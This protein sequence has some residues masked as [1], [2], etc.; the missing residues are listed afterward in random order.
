MSSH[1]WFSPCLLPWYR[2]F[3]RPLP[4]RATRDPYLIWLSET[5]L[6]QTRVDQGLP[7][8]IRFKER[9]PT[10]QALAEANEQEV[11]KAWQ[12]LGYYSRARNL[13]AA[14][15]HVVKEHKGHFPRTVEGLLGLQGVGDYTASAIASICFNRPEAVVDGNVYRV[16]ARVFG[17]GTAID[18]S[19][20][21]KQ[22]KELATALLDPKHPGDHNQAVME[23]GATVCTPKSPDCTY[24]PLHERCIAFAT[25]SISALPVKQGKT[26]ARDRFFNYLHLASSKGIAMQQRQGKDIWTGLFELPLLESGHPLSHRPMEKLLAKTFGKGWCIAAGPAKSRQ[27]LSH[28]VIHAQFWKVIPPKKFKLPDDWKMVPKRKLAE[29]AVPRLID[30]WM[31]DGL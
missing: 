1:S 17:I 23:L 9:W 18:S 25:G 16:L 4:W 20:G 21:R 5:I 3:H 19:A 26:K 11:L 24:C 31:K 28:Q 29:L 6:Q 13:L 27:V 22:F 12:G 8:W 2:D 30:R 14:A 10:V 15:R 7:Y